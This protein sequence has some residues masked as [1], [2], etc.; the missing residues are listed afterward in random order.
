[1]CVAVVHSFGHS[2]SVPPEVG[3]LLVVA[4]A[5]AAVVVPTV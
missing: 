1:M 5:A 4:A 2:S 3:K